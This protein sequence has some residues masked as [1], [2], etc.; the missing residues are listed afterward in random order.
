MKHMNK[1][2]FNKLK[3]KHLIVILISLLGACSRPEFI[4]S[5]GS[6]FEKESLN[7]LSYYSNEFKGESSLSSLHYVSIGNTNDLTVVMVHGTPGSW[8]T[9]RYIL[10]NSRLHD[11]FKLVSLDR[12][13]WGK[14][15]SGDIADTEKF[16]NQVDAIASIVKHA[17]NKPVILIGHS[18]GASLVPKVAIE[19]PELVSGLIL[20]AGSLNPELGKPRWYNKVASLPFMNKLLPDD[21]SKA[22]KEIAV[23]KDG[24]SSYV[25]SWSDIKIPTTV[26]QGKEDKLVNPENVTFVRQKLAHL[27][28]K[29]RIIEIDNMGHFLPWEK[30]ELIVSEIIEM[31]K[32]LTASPQ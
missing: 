28:E 2:A 7:K 6:K 5:A 16:K 17:S 15:T 9:Y 29:L 30:T 8:S 31:K 25:S 18:L 19:H 3:C 32:R 1:N 21:L 11:D 23:L 26:I 12:L 24:L 27:Q 20:L 4:E 10:G 22:N 14:S 13:S